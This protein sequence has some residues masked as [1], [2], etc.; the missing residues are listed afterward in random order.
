MV[1]DL[2]RDPGR[3][4]SFTGLHQRYQLRR[5]RVYDVIN[6]FLGLG[7]SSR[8]GIDGLIWHG[9]PRVFSELRAEKARLG[10]DN[11]A[12]PLSTLFPSDVAADLT[13]LTRGL[14]LLFTALQTE[15]IDL[16]KVSAFFSRG[17]GGYKST[18]CKLYQ[19]AM[20]LSALGITEK[21]ENACEITLLSPF[22]QLLRKDAEENPLAITNLLNRPFDAHALIEARIQEFY[23]IIQID[24]PA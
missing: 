15:T 24:L 3:I 21:G 22:T 2:D 23:G 17:T 14:V 13:T 1:S 4:H 16:R 6:V 20:I 7:C 9:R 12:I 8:Q 11:F 18:L 19:I 5:R 10:V